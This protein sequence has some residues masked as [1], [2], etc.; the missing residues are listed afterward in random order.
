MH[1]LWEKHTWRN[2]HF[3]KRI[4]QIQA[5]PADREVSIMLHAAYVAIVVIALLSVRFARRRAMGPCMVWLAGLIPAVCM[6]A[7]LWHFSEPEKR[8]NDYCKAYQ[9]AARALLSDPAALRPLYKKVDY[10]NIPLVAVAYVPFAR[11]S[12]RWTEVIYTLLG[13]IGIGLAYLLLSRMAALSAIGRL[14]LAGLFV[15]NGPLFNSLRE[16]NSTHFVLLLLVLAL[17]FQQQQRRFLG[18]ALLAVAAW[19]KIPLALFGAWFLLRRQWRVLIGFGLA[20]LGIAILSIA[21]Y[22]FDL[23]EYWFK[24]CIRPFLGRPLGAFNVQSVDG[25]AVRLLS[26]EHPWDWK[27][28]TP[29]WPFHLLRYAMI[30]LL[31]SAVV[32]V[33]RRAQRPLSSAVATV[34][35][36]IVLCLSILLSPISWSHYCLWL[37]LP[38]AYA[39]GPWRRVLESRAW[40]VMWL[41]GMGLSSLPITL[42][43]PGH[44]ILQ[45]LN[46][47]LWVSHTFIGGLL[48]LIV[49]LAVHARLATGRTAE[50]PSRAALRSVPA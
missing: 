31:L 42:L 22:G 26:A 19:I 38:A 49:L 6:I 17:V 21:L 1:K 48:I 46:A 37:L 32:L 16:G 12:P 15:A 50:A 40:H 35:F 28:L 24:R 5:S 27:P 34:E 30:G 8:F 3:G 23:H 2:Q 29:D 41:A 18:G 43:R 7:L 45:E 44:W 13:A 33:T 14:A 11:L 47:R 4:V 39:L 36:C 20:A 25:F 10:V 9:P